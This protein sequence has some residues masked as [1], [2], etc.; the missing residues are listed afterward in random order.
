MEPDMGLSLMN[1]E[2]MTYTK[3]K[4]WMLNQLSHLGT[5]NTADFLGAMDCLV[6]RVP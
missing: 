3:I 4:S 6:E 2:I 5:L 1:C